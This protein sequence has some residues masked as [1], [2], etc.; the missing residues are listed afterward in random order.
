M[1]NRKNA[2]SIGY[3]SEACARFERGVDIKT[4]K[5][6]LIRAVDLL[7][8]YADAKFEGYTHDG[9]NNPEPINITLRYAQIKRILG[10]EIEVD[11]C[12]TILERLGFVIL[13][14]NDAACRVEV[15]SYRAED[16]TREADLIEEI[17]RIYGY[18]K[19]APTL[20]KDRKSVV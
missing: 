19:I 7:V 9:N 15:P 1:P 8:K 13:G 16:V 17:A 14:K 5:P 3:R 11:K 6:A 2:R 10:C 20:P 4:V 18:D 12:L